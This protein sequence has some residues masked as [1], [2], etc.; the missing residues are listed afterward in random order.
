M[1]SGG[2]S[3]LYE[4]NRADLAKASIVPRIHRTFIESAQYSSD[5]LRTLFLPLLMFTIRQFA[6]C[7]STYKVW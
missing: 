7:Y 1:Y 2:Y 4:H 6:Q 5:I 3:G